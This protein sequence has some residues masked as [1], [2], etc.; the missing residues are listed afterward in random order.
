MLPLYLAYKEILRNKTRFLSVS[1]VIAL[2]TLLVLFIAA[3]GEGLAQAG[4]QYIES[5]DAELIVFQ[6]GVDLSV[7]SSR[8]GRSDLNDISRL[9]GVAAVG[10]LGFS[11][12][13]IVLNGE[14][15]ENLD[16]SLVGVEPGQPGAPEVYSGD[17]LISRRANEV[18]IDQNVLDQYEIPVGST[19][20]IQVIQ[21]TE[22]KIYQLRVVGHTSGKQ[23]SFLPSIFVPLLTWDQIKPQ[24]ATGGSNADLTFNVAAVKLTDSAAWE[25]MIP[26]LQ[27]SVR[28]IEVTDPVTTYENAPGYSAQQSTVNTQKGFTLL[29]AVLV[30][31][32]FFQI[33]T[34]QKVGQI[35]MLKAIGASNWLVSISLIVQVILTTIIG[36]AI[37]GA[38]SYLLSVALPAGI[39]IKFEGPAVL[40]SIIFLLAIGPVGGLVS[41]RTLLKVE[42]LTAL[43]LG[44]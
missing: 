12:A 23:Y 2:I 34:L 25:E 36:I 38:V 9:D 6:E 27:E 14:T 39:P 40:T 8:L 17:P 3:L 30:I 1:M 13:S 18:V 24:G 26:F 20:D 29:I 16:V 22:E 21:G 35:G 44:S 28:N 31:G 32:G 4:K 19:I 33:Q 15:G 5:L 41:I 11:V 42:P 37:G 43:G 10:P 7:N